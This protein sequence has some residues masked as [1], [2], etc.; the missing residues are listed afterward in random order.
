MSESADMNEAVIESHGL[1]WKSILEG[2]SGVFQRCL[3]SRT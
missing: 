1:M 3:Y 2:G